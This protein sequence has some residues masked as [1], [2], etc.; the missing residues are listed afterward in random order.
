ML[1]QGYPLPS[2]KTMQRHIRYFQTSINAN[3]F[4]IFWIFFL[5][6]RNVEV[7]LQHPEA[8]YITT[9]ADD[10][11]TETV[12]IHQGDSSTLQ[13][14]VPVHHTYLQTQYSN[15]NQ[16]IKRKAFLVCLY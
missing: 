9:T 5:I 4:K 13:T 2:I 8:T 12:E 3:Y 15:S 14:V 1:E 16:V 6:S 10:S 7:K 11:D